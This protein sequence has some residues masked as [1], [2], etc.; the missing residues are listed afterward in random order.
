MS[1]IRYEKHQ[2]GNFGF[3]FA[4]TN[5]CNILIARQNIVGGI[6]DKFYRCSVFR[7]S[8]CAR[9][10]ETNSCTA[11]L[12]EEREEGELA[13]CLEDKCLLSLT[14]DPTSATTIKV[15]PANLHSLA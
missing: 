11:E 14:D 1:N 10:G 4:K 8:G 13:G 5:R 12:S 3:V 15:G 7:L 6:L 9:A 2:V